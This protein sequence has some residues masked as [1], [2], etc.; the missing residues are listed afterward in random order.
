[1]PTFIIVKAGK[2]TKRLVGLQTKADLVKALA[3]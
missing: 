1:V 2:I 3:L